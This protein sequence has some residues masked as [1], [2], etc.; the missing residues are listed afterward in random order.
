MT[1]QTRRV[2]V[3]MQKCIRGGKRKHWMVLHTQ[4]FMERECVGIKSTQGWLHMMLVGTLHRSTYH[5]AISNFVN[6][7]IDA[8]QKLGAVAAVSSQ[9]LVAA[10]S[11]QAPPAPVA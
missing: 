10:D 7:C 8:L 3:Q 5:H 2:D 4:V 6:D 11:S 9:V 1:G